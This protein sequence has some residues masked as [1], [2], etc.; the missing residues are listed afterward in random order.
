MGSM[1][2]AAPFAAHDYATLVGALIERKRQLGLTNLD[3]DALGGF[4]SGYAGKVFSGMRPLWRSAV[5][6]GRMLEA[7]DARLVLVSER[8]AARFAKIAIPL[9]LSDE[10][11]KDIRRSQWG[12]MGGI[13]RA[14]LLSSKM[15]RAMAR[16]AGKASGAARKAKGERAEPAVVPAQAPALNALKRAGNG[17]GVR[18]PSRDGKGAYGLL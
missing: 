14:H 7:L 4:P 17:P 18:S 2:G 12:R 11:G 1:T 3:V 5:M 8:E 13:K 9:N 15:R 6:I 10:R 16:K